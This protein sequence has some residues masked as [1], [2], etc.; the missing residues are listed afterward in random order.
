MRYCDF[1]E[2]DRPIQEV[3]QPADFLFRGKQFSI[4]Q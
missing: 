4:I 1:C 2:A 3:E